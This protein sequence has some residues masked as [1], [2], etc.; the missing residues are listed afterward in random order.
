MYEGAAAFALYVR[1]RGHRAVDLPHE[2]DVY[3]A[4]ELLWRGVREGGE[5]AYADHVHPGVEPAVL[6][7]RA[8]CHR[9]H[10]L[11]LGRVGDH[12]RRLAAGLLDLLHQRAEPGLAPGRDDDLRAPPG[13]A[14]G[15]LPA[16]AARSPHDDHHLF[17]QRL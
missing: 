14:E 7:R 15:R 16:Y 8:V 5:E 12:G 13:E 11:E 6:L 2:V 1:Q 17:P 4:P 9:L 10:L 3:D